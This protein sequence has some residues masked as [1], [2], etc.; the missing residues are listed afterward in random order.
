MGRPLR[1]TH[2][3]RIAHCF[4]HAVN[5]IWF[6][7]K[8]IR[9]FQSVLR[10][11][12]K[13]HGYVIEYYTILS[14]HC[15]WILRFKEDK[16]CGHILGNI[17]CCLTKAFNRVMER[18][19]HL[20]RERY[21][22]V[23]ICD[24]THYWSATA[25]VA[26][27]KMKAGM[28]D[29]IEQ[30]TSSSFPVYA[31]GVDDGITTVSQEYKAL[32]KTRTERQSEFKRILADSWQAWLDQKTWEAFDQ[33][34]DVLVADGRVDMGELL[35]MFDNE[36]KLLERIREKDRAVE[37]PPFA[38]ATKSPDQ[39]DLY[40]VQHRTIRQARHRALT[41]QRNRRL[42][43]A[44][45]LSQRGIPLNAIDRFWA[46]GDFIVDF[47]MEHYDKFDMDAPPSLAVQLN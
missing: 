29:C 39:D 5:G 8:D 27:N 25:Y 9:I 36:E 18:K 12:V 13:R 37:I 1:V 43:M 46:N 11:L 16:N 40:S 14:N 44:F 28:I 34:K 21:K 33:D 32:G 35:N 30:D 10:T 45:D 26:L 2:A 24:V 38:T 22:D 41:Y 31:H 3:N 7:E 19:G 23:T 6:T 47:L 42:E 4:I 17:H 15:H 20:W